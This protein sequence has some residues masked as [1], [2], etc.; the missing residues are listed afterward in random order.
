M[1]DVKFAREIEQIGEDAFTDERARRE[2][3]DKLFGG[4]RQNATNGDTALFQ[5]ADQIERFVGGDAA[6][7]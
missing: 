6:R 4:F 3:R 7:R 1:A 2:W 5:S